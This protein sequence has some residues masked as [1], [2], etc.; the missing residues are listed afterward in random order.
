MNNSTSR[1]CS[2]GNKRSGFP[3]ALVFLG[4]NGFSFS[5]AHE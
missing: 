1:S 3:V 4:L 2:D 5:R